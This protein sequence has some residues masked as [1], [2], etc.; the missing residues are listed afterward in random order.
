MCR[1]TIDGFWIGNCNYSVIVKWHT[2]FHYSL[3]SLLCLH[4][5][6]SSDG[7]QHCLL[8][9]RSR[10]YRLASV[11]ELTHCQSQNQSQI[12]SYVSLSS[13]IWGPKPDFFVTVRQ[14]R[15]CS[16]CAPS[17]TIGR[18]CRLYRLADIAPIVLLITS[19]HGSH[20]KHRF[21]VAA[22]LLLSGPRRKH[23]SSVVVCGPLHSNGSTCHSIKKVVTKC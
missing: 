9:P 10:S 22:Q 19:R 2:T 18:V 5:S 12:E 14:F 6:L 23:H 8:L 17:L 16:Y 7:S 4:Q 20:R 13:R 21:S 3:L 1:S 15:V 11:S